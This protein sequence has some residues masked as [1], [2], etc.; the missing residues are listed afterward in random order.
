MINYNNE[1]EEFKNHLF[2]L[3]G[4]MSIGI[5][6]QTSKIIDLVK[7]FS[8]FY[9]MVDTEN[10]RLRWTEYCSIMSNILTVWANSNAKLSKEQLRIL[11]KHKSILSS[12]FLSGYDSQQRALLRQFK[13][14]NNYKQNFTKIL[15]LISI[16]NLNQKLFRGY[17]SAP[18]LEALFLSAGWLSERT[19]MTRCAAVYHQKLVDDFKRFDHLSID[20]DF[21]P[22]LS[23]CYM[24][25]TYSNSVGK[26]KIKA[27]IHNLISRTIHCT[28]D[29]RALEF[30]RTKIR[31]KPKII[32]V[33]E[34]FSD[35]HV[36]MRCHLPVLS[37]LDEEFDVGHLTWSMEDFSETTRRVKRVIKCADNLSSIIATIKIEDPDIILYPSIGMNTLVI[38]L[39]SLRLAPLQLQ[40][41]GHPSS[42]HSPSIDGSLHHNRLG[43]LNSGPEKFATYEGYREGMH[44]PFTL[45]E[46]QAKI[47]N[48]PVSSKTGKF[49]IA[50][51]AKVM[52]LCPDFMAFL[53]SMDWP[54]KNIQLNFFP[55]EA[56]TEYFAC[57]NSIHRYFPTANVHHMSDYESFMSELGIQDLAICAFP[58]GNTNGI[59]DC[60][61]L[62]L[63]TFVLQGTEVCSASES[64]ILLAHGLHD[65]IYPN[66]KKLSQ[67]VTK[68]LVDDSWRKDVRKAFKCKSS[69]YREKNSI[70]AA[71]AYEAL[72]HVEWIRDC[73][74]QY[75]HDLTYISQGF[76]QVLDAPKTPPI[77]VL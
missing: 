73:I 14:E 63:P 68:F 48:T 51:N 42:S 57:C 22:F 49:N 17:Q 13:Q 45:K 34:Y 62:G 54:A 20:L 55:A 38:A 59:L 74:S 76:G 66:K 16:N 9:R 64:Q 1:I 8:S 72:N 6:L 32:I 21:I 71:Q 12:I 43:F 31:K 4:D 67:G 18:D 19:Q 52:K 30:K 44:M 50:I 10:V 28:S 65:F 41:F 69:I 70:S 77:A 24:Y 60:L 5:E 26:D 25:T 29:K 15:L 40:L 27:T 46:M 61:Y 35:T 39:A 23:K 58:F 3:E 53:R 37:K 33:H 2:D 47:S 75:N 56:G 11:A 36:M 7:T